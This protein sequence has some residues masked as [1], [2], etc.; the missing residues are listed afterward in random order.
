MSVGPAESEHNSRGDG[1][2]FDLNEVTS[3]LAQVEFLFSNPQATPIRDYANTYLQGYLEPLVDRALAAAEQ[4]SQGEGHAP[5]VTTVETV[6]IVDDVVTIQRTLNATWPS[7]RGA[8]LSL[9]AQM[10]FAEY[11]LVTSNEVPDTLHLEDDLVRF[12]AT[13][14]TGSLLPFTASQPEHQELER[15]WA[16]LQKVARDAVYSDERCTLFEEPSQIPTVESVEQRIGSSS[17]FVDESRIPQP[18]SRS[19]RD[20]VRS[21][22][23]K[24][25]SYPSTAPKDETA[26]TQWQ[27]A[28]DAAHRLLAEMTN[29][30]DIGPDGFLARSL[31]VAGTFLN[32][33]EVAERADELKRAAELERDTMS[34]RADSEFYKLLRNWDESNGRLPPASGESV[35]KAERLVALGH[36]ETVPHSPWA[37]VAVSKLADNLDLAGRHV[38]AAD[39][40]LSMLAADQ[41]WKVVSEATLQAYAGYVRN[42]RLC[43]DF[44]RADEVLD[45]MNA[46]LQRMPAGQTL[47]KTLLEHEFII[48]ELRGFPLQAHDPMM[49]NLQTRSA[50]NLTRRFLSMDRG[51]SGS[52]LTFRCMQEQLNAYIENDCAR[53]VSAMIELSSQP[54]IG[55]DGDFNR[56]WPTQKD[57][58]KMVTRPAVRNMPGLGVKARETLT[59]L[60]MPSDQRTLG[61]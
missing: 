32:L 1:Q 28:C 22:G 44:Q 43:G 15:K 12:V 47:G 39:A 54:F 52:A 35:A 5:E 24:L 8:L 2:K 30:R 4:S 23:I 49:T 31:A 57:L 38:E 61:F 11:G 16:L 58:V 20:D 7:E 45:G 3:W 25:I 21:S 40:Y 27:A 34:P 56:G 51:T 46:T 10:D 37:L 48:R 19:D 41:Y 36:I 29:P 14:R 9:Q 18:S 50:E 59:N 53:P 13:K 42:T 55:C 33:P 17:Y 6:S 26:F 60:G